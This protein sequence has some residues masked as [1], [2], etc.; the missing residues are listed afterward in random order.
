MRSFVTLGSPI[1]KYLTIWWSN[2]RYLLKCDGRIRKREQKIPHFN[3]CDELDP[4]GHEL[5]VLRKTPVYKAVFK[6]REDVVFNRYSV[7]GVAHNK[8]WTDQGLFRWIIDRAVGPVNKKGAE[9][10]RWFRRSSYWKVLF[11]L[12]SLVPLLVLL[13]TYASLTL[14]FQADGWRTAGMSAA[15]F[16]FLFFFGSRLIDLSTWWRQIQRK[17]SSRFWRES[18]RPTKQE[19]KSRRTGGVVF[20]SLAFTAPL[21]SAV[22]TLVASH[23]FVGRFTDVHGPLWSAPFPPCSSESCAVRLLVVMTVFVAIGLFAARRRLPVA[24]RVTVHDPKYCSKVET[25]SMLVSG[26]AAMV[27]ALLVASR[28]ALPSLASVASIP[29][30]DTYRLPTPWLGQ[31]ALLGILATAVYGYRLYCFLVV[32]YVLQPGRPEETDYEAYASDTSSGDET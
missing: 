12:Y 3:F 6:C 2:Y 4:V 29:A 10:P 25:A 23:K 26:V 21:V 24:Y 31:L 13:G 9:Q 32:K 30:E 11:W 5:D 8:Y 16:S 1:D 17:K 18:S 28:F 14:A 15:V 27:L 7:P 20:R 19:R 22:L